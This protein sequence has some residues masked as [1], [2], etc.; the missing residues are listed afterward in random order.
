M[1]TLLTV[2]GL[3][4]VALLAGAAFLHLLP[5]LGA[6]GR[7]IS[8]AACRAPLLDVVITYF[9]VAPLFAGPIYGGWAG[10]GGA[11]AGQVASVLFWG[12]AHELC[13]LDAV[14]GPRIVR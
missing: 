14:R 5:R 3:T 13:N 11:V 10:F 4:C 2:A 8:A 6:P 12:W 1:N 9:T 7:A